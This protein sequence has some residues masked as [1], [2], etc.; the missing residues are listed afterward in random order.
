MIQVKCIEKFRDNH[1]KI[2]GYRLIDLN[3]KTQDVRPENLKEA[4]KNNKIHVINLKL[5]SDGRLV[6]CKEHILQD[7]NLGTAPNEMKSKSDRLKEW[8]TSFGNYVIS[9]FGQGDINEIDYYEHNDVI[10][11]SL[12]I[13]SV[14]SVGKG[15]DDYDI[16]FILDATISKDDMHVG[17][18]VTFLDGDGLAISF[19]NKKLKAPVISKHNDNVIKSMIDEAHDLYL[20]WTKGVIDAPVN[21]ASARIIDTINKATGVT[22]KLS[23]SGKYNCGGDIYTYYNDYQELVV[24]ILNKPVTKLDN[25]KDCKYENIIKL[26]GRN[27]KQLTLKLSKENLKTVIDAIK[28]YL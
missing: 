11:I 13:F 2:Y 25:S 20:K 14:D 12:P 28:E 8:F 4:I 19:E 23:S 27:T 6:D 7:S 17:C 26:M 15:E 18:I 21:A 3:N 24:E 9:I 16:Q 22:F 10:D 1:G 5:T